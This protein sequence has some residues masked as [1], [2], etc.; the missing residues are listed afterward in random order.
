MKTLSW[1]PQ[2][3]ITRIESAVEA[4]KDTLGNRAQAI[5]LIGAALNAARHDRSQAPELLVITES[6]DLDDLRAV[7]KHLH[8]AM[9]LGVRIKLLTQGELES[10][11][12]VFALEMAD[13]RDRHV[14][15]HGKDPFSKLD[16]SQ[17]DLRRSVEQSL[18]G[19]NRRMRNR[20][21]AA[22]GTDGQRGDAQV[23]VAEAINRLVV[24]AHH[25]L[26]L[27]GEE[28][29]RTETELLEALCEHADVG[30]EA[31]LARLE[32]LRSGKGLG[33]AI[34]AL[35]NVMDVSLAAGRW[36]DQLQVSG[37]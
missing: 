21:L 3:T 13:Y 29:P 22:M 17:A 37:A 2:E 7:A 23:A 5:V 36:V 10:S 1:L 15:L 35:G 19:L 20:V 31:I 24:I 16:I 11:A 8:D 18:R 26:A 25:A 14:L 27:T 4:L 12:D 30:S 32:R 9:T 33:D 6:L 34:E 28:P